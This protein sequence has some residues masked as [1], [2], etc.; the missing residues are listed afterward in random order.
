MVGYNVQTGDKDLNAMGLDGTAKVQIH[1]GGVNGNKEEA[2][3]RFVRTITNSGR[4]IDN[5][6]RRWLVIENDE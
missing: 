4:F 2:I 3:N 1:V 6:I 5:A